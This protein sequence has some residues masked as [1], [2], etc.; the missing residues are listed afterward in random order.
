MLPAIGYSHKVPNCATSTP[1]AAILKPSRVWERGFMS[2]G[3][4]W[5]I[6]RAAASPRQPTASVAS[7]ASGLKC[8][9]E[10]RC[11]SSAVYKPTKLPKTAGAAT[12]TDAVAR[13]VNTLMTGW[14]T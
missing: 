2:L 12:K 4:Q 11:A 7:R 13:F 3:A 10:I 9:T 14:Y 1:A 5:R 8:Q 6:V